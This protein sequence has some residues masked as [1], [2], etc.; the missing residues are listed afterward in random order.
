MDTI[1][2][3][4]V[5]FKIVPITDND[6]EVVINSL[7]QYFFRDEPL[8]ASSGL[9]EEKESV[10]ELENFCVDLLRNGEFIDTNCKRYTLNKYMLLP[11]IVH[12]RIRYYCI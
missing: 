7:K 4:K 10:I 11:I 9:M 2:S 8:C 1:K 3:T 5:S 12:L 6:K